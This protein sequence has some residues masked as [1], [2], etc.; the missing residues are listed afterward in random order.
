MRM[1][2]EDI[3]FLG[4]AA[5]LFTRPLFSPCSVRL[6]VLCIFFAIIYR[7]IDYFVVHITSEINGETI[8]FLYLRPEERV[9]LSLIDKFVTSNVISWIYIVILCTWIYFKGTGIFFIPPLWNNLF[10]YLLPDCSVH[11]SKRNSHYS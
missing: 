9:I 6:S 8:Y 11:V 1:R 10:L 4:W 7:G 2:S 3:I 5:F